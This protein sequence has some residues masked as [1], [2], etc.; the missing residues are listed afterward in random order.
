MVVVIA[1]AAVTVALVVTK[2]NDD[3]SNVTNGNTIIAQQVTF[4]DLTSA[5]YSG[6]WQSAYELGYGKALGLVAC[7]NSICSY[8]PEASVSSTV[9]SRRSIVVTFQT[10]APTQLIST[11]QATALVTAEA[12]IN[13]TQQGTGSLLTLALTLTLTVT[14]TLPT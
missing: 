14:L 4:T 10:T 1:A 11:T 9:A 2:D 3:D 6:A 12:L 8:I 7:A 5:Q 13:Q